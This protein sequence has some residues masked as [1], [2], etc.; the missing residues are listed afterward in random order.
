M[1][2]AKAFDLVDHAILLTKLQAYGV[3]GSRHEWF[4][5]YLQDRQHRVDMINCMIIVFVIQY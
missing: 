5:N 3:A 2:F 4:K 1:D